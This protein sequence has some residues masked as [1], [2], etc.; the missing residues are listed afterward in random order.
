MDTNP[1][2]SPASPESAID[3]ATAEPVTIRR[4]HLNHET[5]VKFFGILWVIGSIAIAL[6]HNNSLNPLLFNLILAARGLAALGLFMRKSWAPFLA[7]PVA[8][9]S[10]WP[11][12]VLSC[13]ANLTLLY[14]LWSAKGRMLF[15]P[16]H[17]AIIAATPEIKCGQ[18]RAAVG[19][20]LFFVL[21]L[22][23][24]QLFGGYGF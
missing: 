17:K 23:H 22:L 2:Q 20:L 3:I 1:Y 15:R 13:I 10:L 8:T 4:E 21:A 18:S 19:I 7:T 14:T 5:I 11:F 9:Y 24:S 16:E 12:S 6:L